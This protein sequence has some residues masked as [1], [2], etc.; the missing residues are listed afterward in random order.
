MAV[1]ILGRFVKQSGETLRYA[2]DYTE[3][4]AEQDDTAVSFTVDV[5]PGITEVASTRLAGVVSIILSGGTS[6]QSY[7]ITVLLTTADGLVKEAD[8]IVKVKDV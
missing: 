3:W 5:D 4:L 7:K 2:V 8:F 1:S 6:G